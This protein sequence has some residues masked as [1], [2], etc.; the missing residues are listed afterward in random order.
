M[1]NA[2]KRFEDVKWRGE[3]A[4]GKGDLWDFEYCEPRKYMQILASAYE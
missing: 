3:S 2:R 4:D 1:N